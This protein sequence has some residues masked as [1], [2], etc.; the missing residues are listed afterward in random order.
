MILPGLDCR[1]LRR[2]RLG[3]FDL[4]VDFFYEPTTE[5]SC[6][7]NVRKV[8]TPLP[9]LNLYDLELSALLSC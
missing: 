1:L 6:V 7:H 4:N 5:S 3:A 2:S 8:V 9:E